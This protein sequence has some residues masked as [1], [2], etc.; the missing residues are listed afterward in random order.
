MHVKT[1]KELGLALGT[2][3]LSSIGYFFTTGFYPVWWL[4]WFAPIPILL[5]ALRFSFKSTLIVAFLV[6]LIGK[7]WLNRT[8][9]NVGVF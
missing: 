6:G 5:Y 3:L 4:A 1:K 2:I 8:G 9:Q 7:K